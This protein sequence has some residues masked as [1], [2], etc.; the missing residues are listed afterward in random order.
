MQSE[1]HAAAE[2]SRQH[3]N[4]QKHTNLGALAG[5]LL[6]LL[7][8][9][10]ALLGTQ[11]LALVTFAFGILAIGYAYACYYQG[12]AALAWG[13]AG[14]WQ[15]SY[16][17][18]LTR[19]LVIESL[20][21]T[22][23]VLKQN[24]GEKAPRV[25]SAF[26]RSLSSMLKAN[27]AENY[28]EMDLKDGETQE[29]IVLTVCKSPTQT[30]HAMRKQAEKERDEAR[31]E[32]DLYLSA[33][34]NHKDETDATQVARVSLETAEEELAV[35]AAQAGWTEQD[36]RSVAQFLRDRLVLVTHDRDNLE[37]NYGC[38]LDDLTGGIL[39]KCYEWDTVRQFLEDNDQHPQ[40]LRAVID[41][42]NKALEAAVA[43]VETASLTEAA[44]R[45][46]RVQLDAA[47]ADANRLASAL[48]GSKAAIDDPTL[49]GLID[50]ALNH[51]E[52]PQPVAY[53]EPTEVV[54]VVVPVETPVSEPEPQNY[55]VPD[56]VREASRRSEAQPLEP[57]QG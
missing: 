50:S 18:L 10:F 15:K 30:P 12:I 49:L 2:A 24:P 1:D 5:G 43:A 40:Q 14:A 57:V 26:A 44:N 46:L 38:L 11:T 48:A 8:L 39:S 56:I 6:L 22:G 21:T 3:A 4:R 29:R 47:Q 19:G 7:S 53:P 23:F 27:G 35:I 17:D 51:H 34:Q 37:Y 28:L 54:E 16:S 25:I 55:L 20:D 9:S 45:R 36:G 41:E 33:I 42:Q 32:R 52:N 31:R 13:E